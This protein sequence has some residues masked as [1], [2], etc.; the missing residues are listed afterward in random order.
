MFLYFLYPLHMQYS[1]FNI[2]KYITF[3]T[4]G[5]GITSVLLCM[6]VGPSFIRWLQRKQ[7]GQT[8]RDD[9]PKTHLSKKG[10]PTMGGVLIL[11][12]ITISTLLWADLSNKNIWIALVT[13]ILLG[14]L[15]YIDD[16]R[17]VIQKNSK[18]L[19]F[20]QK[21][22]AQVIIAGLAAYVIEPLK[23]TAI[24]QLVAKPS[25]LAYMP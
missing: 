10:T 11:L 18:G 25:E 3:R 17:K 15:G 14:I 1:F 4:F 8:V 5:A 9:G 23:I 13:T 21:I 12:S 20:N 7:I 2:F 24:K 6:I 19:S 22:I 16:F